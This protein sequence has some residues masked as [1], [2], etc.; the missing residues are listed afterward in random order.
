MTHYYSRLC[1]LF[2][3]SMRIEQT[4]DKDFDDLCRPVG[5]TSK[6]E[7]IACMVNGY[8]FNFGKKCLIL[9][10]AFLAAG[11]S[12]YSQ[13]SSI[14][15]DL[16]GLNMNF[17][18][19]NRTLI[20]DAGRNGLDVGSVWRYDNLVTAKGVTIY[21]I[22]TVKEKSPNA[23]L[24][25]L[26]S[27][28]YGTVDRFQPTIN[29]SPNN[30]NG[31][32]GYVLFEL[33]FYEVITDSR[34]YVSDY[35]MTVID[36]DGQSA[37]QREF[38]EIGGYS[39]YTVDAA[40]EQLITHNPVTGRTRFTAK[41]T[42]IDPMLF[43]NTASFIAHYVFP[44]TKVSFALGGN[45]TNSDRQYS[46]QFGVAGGSF[47]NPT[48]AKN[49]Q[50]LL[51]MTKESDSDHFAGGSWHPYTITIENFGS[52]ADSIVLTDPLPAHLTYV[53]NSTRV[54]IPATS[55]VE[56]VSDNFNQRI[57][58]INTGSV[59]W[60]SDWLE[61]E[62]TK[63]AT[64][65]AISITTNGVLM[66][67]STNTTSVTN[68]MFID[69]VVDLSRAQSATLTF[70]YPAIS[71][72]S[73]ELSVQWSRDGNAYV[74]IGTSLTGT[75][76]GKFTYSFPPNF[77]NAGND[78]S[79][80]HLR[81]VNA[82]SQWE[83]NRSI[84]IDNVKIEYGFSQAARTLTNAAVGGTLSNG[85]PSN[86]LSQA[87][88][89]TLLPGGKATVT[90]DVD[91]ACDAA[92]TILNTATVTCPHLYQNE[93]TASHTAYVNPRDV[94]PANICA[95]SGGGAAP[96]TLSASGK[97]G[98]Q[99]FRWYAAESGG[100]PLH[101]G[102]SY[103]TSVSATTNYYVSF[104]NPDTQCESG[105]TKVT[106]TVSPGLSGTG[107]ITSGTARNGTGGAFADDQSSVSFKIEGVTGATGYTWTVPTGATITYGQGTDR[108]LVDFNNAGQ[109]G[110][111]NVS[112][113]PE[114][115]CANGAPVILSI[116]ITDNTNNE[117]SGTVYSTLYSNANTPA[118]VVGTGGT[119]IS[120][121]GGQQLYATLS[122]HSTGNVITSVPVSPD[123]TYKFSY[124][125]NTTNNYYRVSINTIISST[126]GLPAGSAWSG[127]RDN[128]S[129]NTQTGCTSIIGWLQVTAGNNT[130]NTNVNFGIKLPN[131][132]AKDDINQTFEGMPVSGNLLTNDDVNLTK[133]TKVTIGGSA[134]DV[135]SNGTEIDIPDAGK[136]KVF[137]DGSYTFTPKQGYTGSVPPIG[138]TATN[139]A[140]TAESKLYISVTTKLQ[141]SGTN[142]PPIA[143]HDEAT[144]QQG[145]SVTV[146]PLANDSDPDKDALS[147]TSVTAK[148]SGNNTVTLTT[149]NQNIYDPTGTTVIGQARRGGANNNEVIF[150]A[151]SDYTGDVPF[152]Y[153]ISDGKGATA[154]STIN[155]KVTTATTPA[156]V[157]NDDAQA[158]PKGETIS[159]D[160]KNNDM[161]G[162][163]NPHING[164]SVNYG[165]VNTT[166]QIGAETTIPGVGKI[167]LIS[168]GTYTFV[169]N[170]DFTGTMPVVYK[171]VNNE[172]ISD[173]A[174]LYLTS[175]PPKDQLWIGSSDPANGTD[176]NTP[177]NW[178]TN[179]VPTPGDNIIFATAEN[180]SG[181]PAVND[182]YVPVGTPV[183][184]NDL[185]NESNKALVVPPTAS[186]TITGVVIGSETPGD[187]NKIRI[188]AEKEKANGSFIVQNEDPCST[189][190]YATVEMWSPA[191]QGASSTWVDNVVGSPTNGQDFTS[192]YLWQ[193]FGV[194]VESIGANPAFA[195][196]FLRKYDETINGTNQFY[197]KW[198]D[199]DN[200][201]VLEAFKGYEVT[202]EA[203]RLFTI[204]GK[205]NFCDATLT[206]TRKAPAVTGATGTDEHYGLGQNIFANSFTSAIKIDKI[207]FPDEAQQTIY[208]YTTGRFGDWA[209]KKETELAYKDQ[210]TAGSYVAV[211]RNTPFV[212]ANEIPS[213]QGFLLK[214]LPPETTFNGSDVKV[215][216][217]YANGDIATKN[218]VQTRSAKAKDDS[219]LSYLHLN[220]QNESTIDNLWLVERE[221]TVAGFDN[222]WDGEKFFETP[223][224]FIYADTPD[225]PMQVSTN[226]T[227]IGSAISFRAN[228]T[229]EYLLTLTK[230]N[231]GND[232]DLQL[233]DRLEK[234]TIPLT[235]DTISYR[236]N[237]Q[238]GK[239]ENRFRIQDAKVSTGLEEGDSQLMTAYVEG[240]ELVVVNYSGAEVAL[241]LYSASGQ[242]LMTEIAGTTL[243]KYPLPYA[244]GIYLLNMEG[245][246]GTKKTVKI[247]IK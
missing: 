77:F 235:E 28:A 107:T 123:G 175:I 238:A 126:S 54:S 9:L 166:L 46:V 199:L 144:I 63:S 178:N 131:P 91:V 143:N 76:A 153:S 167:T 72:S 78:N 198:E 162:G 98:N 111:Y 207:E 33:E 29:V 161:W 228:T 186:I 227:L 95:P 92:G 231:L 219:L 83:T 37:T 146:K 101:T 127:E 223:T 61:S 3:H 233:V 133:V 191:Y 224:A 114:G 209:E 245:V 5:K 149:S 118:V 234:V 205:L 104:Y 19:A 182:L 128:N 220:L 148:G 43:E 57:Y 58:G 45:R 119:P 65:G 157:A 12:L 94:T 2:P 218:T 51:Y 96:V 177:S 152:N 194:P 13:S 201:S 169:P 170:L 103:T 237:S 62:T 82:G 60:K 116:R 229:G 81:F 246:T 239:F 73:G 113:T 35:Y 124:L 197:Q 7:R 138:Y 30:A 21:G 206:M 173:K 26:D 15:L 151:D 172:G 38:V 132:V 187:V 44:Y 89:I 243:S 188:K 39:F 158:A 241:S 102:D 100:E 155:V 145:L 17:R 50:K 97:Q 41:P 14:V 70:D 125:S 16:Q 42:T 88:K 71:L 52:T 47:N 181:K 179:M 184:I 32:N 217:K 230:N 214:F 202:Q 142:N 87:D 93:I 79:S 137:P 31:D 1:A 196:S 20:T 226:E 129:N 122:Q 195:G 85:T 247:V 180:N 160:V 48:T 56:T 168:N 185:T 134:V 67:N 165:G 190:V 4:D 204:P 84:S 159:G 86:I 174:T 236:F 189:I 6:P 225:G 53:P 212:T 156:I 22:V 232:A 121:I 135:V 141:A 8:G 59:Q 115:P 36:N 216:L 208:I 40:S 192:S 211:P 203:P 24:V 139:S 117:I 18:N 147:V 163:G 10:V 11:F 109:S 34:V 74:T 240:Q 106:A 150:T 210:R 176:W 222:G 27:E 55:A 183:E 164:A 242:K 154:A 200:S 108:I 25:A 110:D 213:M 221:G 99:V 49:P 215:S 140:Q 244:S 136:I 105:R 75:T 68:G 64:A 90:F 66:F 130:N 23:T 69:R 112:A 120:S 171:V 80:I 193:Y